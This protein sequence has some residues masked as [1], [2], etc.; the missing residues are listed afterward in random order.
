MRPHQTPSAGT[1]RKI[2]LLVGLPALAL[3]GCGEGLSG[4]D[5]VQQVAGDVSALGAPPDAASTIAFE[6]FSDDVGQQAAT[7]T[8]TLIRTARGYQSLFGHAPPAS[9]DFSRDW[10][11]FYAAGTEPTGG[12]EASFL[13]LLRSGPT[14]IAI[15][16]VVSPG[17]PCVVDD[18]V[19]A[20]YALVKFPAQPGASAQFY[21]NDVVQD[22]NVD[23]CASTD[24]GPGT[25]CDKGTCVVSCGGLSGAACPGSGKCVDDPTDRCD[26]AAGGAD[27]PG[28][29]TCVETVLCTTTSKF[30]G[31]PSVCAC[32]PAT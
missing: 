30:D 10:V 1:V 26:P 18:R 28:I 31:S 27:C 5:D 29:C 21:K 15:T 19:T 4:T 20:P 16:Q 6:T 3:L 25:R 9:V 12:Y 22:C 14:L 13:F 8:R 32:V 7:K 24:C 11:M 2:S 23:P 17:P